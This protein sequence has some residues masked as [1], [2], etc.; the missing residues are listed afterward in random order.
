LDSVGLFKF[1][2]GRISFGIIKDTE[3]AEELLGYW[4]VPIAIFVSVLL[5]FVL[6]KSL[7]ILTIRRR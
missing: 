6:T 3:Y 7:K 1:L 5:Y 4:I 2:D